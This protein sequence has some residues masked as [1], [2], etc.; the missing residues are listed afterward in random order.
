M[1]ASP[2]P[3]LRA[4]RLPAAEYAQR[5]ADA[6]PPLT[7]A[8]AVLE[9]E[10][11]VYCHDAPCQT[12]CPTGI[13]VPQFIRRIGDGNLRG[14]AQA[15]L[16][17]NPLGGMCAR[18]CPTEELCEQVCVRNTQQGQP[19][20]I[21]RLQRH[22]VDAVMHLPLPSLLP[23]AP[24]TGRH[25]AVVGAGPAGLACAQQLAL[26]GHRVTVLD[27]HERLGGLN[28]YGLARYKTPG[29]FAQREVA[30]LLG[31][32]DIQ[33]RTGWRLDTPEQLAELRA[34]HD[35]VFLGIGLGD[36][37]RLGLPGEDLAGVEDAVAF[38]ARLRQTEDLST[39]PVGRRVVVI[40]GGMTA[41]DAAVQ[42][43]LL[44]A[45]QVTL[46]YRRGPEAMGAS[47]DEQRW[48]LQNGVVI[49]HW[50]APQA[51]VGEGGA[52]QAVTLAQQALVDGRLQPTG[53]TDTL[54][55]D[56]LLKAIGQKLAV[57]WAAA[58]GLTTAAGKLVADEAGATALPGVWA[59]GDCVAGG[60]DLTVWAVEH[61]KR[62]AQAIHQYLIG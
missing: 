43:K 26:L 4:G 49:R 27:A 7:P 42:C 54:P 18:V 11:C 38:I 19:I 28:E 10:R 32:G 14:A 55:A 37:Q 51:L 24:A 35:A 21:G 1:T 3:D 61:G 47:V 30:W 31:Q 36:T 22:A 46:A 57:P 40:G 25:V 41:V 2:A 53:A 9:A 34:G 6:Q 15:I 13:P 58:A 8:Q 60:R 56:L 52:L 62:A 23:S 5:F 45:E 33:V 20:A 59:G 12:A 50:V 16:A 29:D 17:A 48:A 44:G 39:L